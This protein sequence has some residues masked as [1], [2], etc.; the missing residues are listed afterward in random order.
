[1]CNRVLIRL[2]CGKGSSIKRAW[3]Y[4]AKQ[5][6]DKK[7]KKRFISEILLSIESGQTEDHNPNFYK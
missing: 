4:S 6:K 5:K 2:D 7:E 1:M 3:L